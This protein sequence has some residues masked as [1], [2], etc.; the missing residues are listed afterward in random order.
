MRESLYHQTLQAERE[1]ERFATAATDARKRE[2]QL[3]IDCE[4]AQSQ[5]HLMTQGNYKDMEQSTYEIEKL[6]QQVTTTAKSCAVMQEDLMEARSRELRLQDTLQK[7]QRS[8]TSLAKDNQRLQLAYNETTKAAEHELTQMQ[9][10]YQ[11]NLST[12]GTS[13]ELAQGEHTKRVQQ[14]ENS[15]DA[16]K[17][18]TRGRLQSVAE[19][20]PG[21]GGRA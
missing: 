3:R 19:V 18:M 9:T 7:A 21:R 13:M 4:L 16:I 8:T 14:L 17:S 2:E 15:Q 12:L 1:R 10:Q 6:R 11:Q 5:L 20:V